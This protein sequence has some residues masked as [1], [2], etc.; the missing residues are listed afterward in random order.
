M[1]YAES[2]VRAAI[3]VGSN[4]IHI[5]VARATVQTLDIL[6]DEVEL[7]RIG[8]SVTASGQISQDKC[9]YAVSV[10]ARYK[11]LAEQYGAQEIF[12][13]ATEAIRQASNSAEFIET[14]RQKT[15]LTVELISGDAE[16]T[17]TFAGA[18]YEAQA[19][20]HPPSVM[21]VMDLWGGS[22]ELVTARQGR[23]IWKT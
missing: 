9:D 14:I 19:E 4:T 20:A 10:L 2:P 8:E 11:A 7:V 5:V 17:L 16:A 18:S 23:I 21:S 12:V 3:D 6:A 15:G 22:L 13:V 1:Q